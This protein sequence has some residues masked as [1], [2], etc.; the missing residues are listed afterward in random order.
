MKKLALSLLLSTIIC[1][2]IFASTNVQAATVTSNNTNT[3][4][5]V[6]MR[7]YDPIFRKGSRSEDLKPIQDHLLLDGFYVGRSYATDYYKVVD[8]IFG[9]ETEA[10][11]KAFQRYY[12]IPDDGII[13]PQTWNVIHH[14]FF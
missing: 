5:I 2:G 12:G 11:V 8:G 13:G 6:S 9:D 4:K 1:T 3:K 10:A 7:G 14:T